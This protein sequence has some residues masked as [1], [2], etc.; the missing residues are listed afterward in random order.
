MS[1]I[2]PFA[3]QLKSGSYVCAAPGAGGADEARLDI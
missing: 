3:F 2:G 1:P